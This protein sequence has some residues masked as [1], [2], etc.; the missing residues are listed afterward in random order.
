MRVR[1]SWLQ[2]G[3]AVAVVAAVAVLTAY[4]VNASGQKVERVESNNSGLWATSDGASDAP[5][6]YG[7]FNK[8]ASA[9]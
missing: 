7:R 6:S 5:G 3:P 9:L 1:R 2:V 8:A 4:A